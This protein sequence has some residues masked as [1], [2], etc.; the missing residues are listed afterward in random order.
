MRTSTTSESFLTNLDKCGIKRRP[1]ATE[2]EGKHRVLAELVDIPQ[3]KASTCP[4]STAGSGIP[5]PDQNLSDFGASS[6]VQDSASTTP[7]EGS[8][9]RRRLPG[10][11]EGSD[12]YDGEFDPRKERYTG[13]LLAPCHGYC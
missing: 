9:G 3:D 4:I 5:V 10:L 12:Y 8:A 6:S 7:E 11:K 13:T 1:L 2:Q